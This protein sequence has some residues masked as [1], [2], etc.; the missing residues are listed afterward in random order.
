M[1][2]AIRWGLMVILHF[3]VLRR[4][5]RKTF[6]MLSLKTDYPAHAFTV[7]LIEK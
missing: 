3:F 2:Y 4:E 1:K 6:S 5:D 7:N